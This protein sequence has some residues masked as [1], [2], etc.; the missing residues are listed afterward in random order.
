MDLWVTEINRIVA[1]TLGNPTG[2]QELLLARL[3]ATLLI[4]V[5]FRLAS[6]ANRLPETG[7]VRNMGALLLGLSILLISAAG[8][9]LYVM[10][11]LSHTPLGSVVVLLV[12][13]VITLAI[14]V[15]LQCR[16]LKAD[17][18]GTLMS[19]AACLIVTI[20]A[21]SIAEVSLDS[22]RVGGQKSSELRQRGQ[23][24]EQLIN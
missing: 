1:N 13:I 6:I 17:Y 16:I 21:L 10:P 18:V 15:P 11:H 9:S 8:M 5:S 4:V 22:L 14:G 2:A 20:V 3:F 19:F 7:L 24:F 12:P 23:A